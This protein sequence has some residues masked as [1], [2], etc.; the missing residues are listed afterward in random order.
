MQL[1]R[2]DIKKVDNASE[3]L[4]GY[5]SS[6]ELSWNNADGS[7]YYYTLQINGLFENTKEYLESLDLPARAAD[8]K[9]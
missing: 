8:I 4:N 2:E 9:G 5:D 6:Y 3:F 7:H 1:Y